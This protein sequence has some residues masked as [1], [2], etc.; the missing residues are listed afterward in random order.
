MAGTY[1]LRL[2]AAPGR[3]AFY[4]MV[5]FAFNVTHPDNLTYYETTTG[6]SLQWTLRDSYPA[7]PSTVRVYRNDTPGP[8]LE[9]TWTWSCEIDLPVEG[10]SPGWYEYTC[11]VTHWTGIPRNDTV[12]VHVLPAVLTLSSPDNASFVFGSAPEIQWAVDA[13]FVDVTFYNVSLGTTELLAGSWVPGSTI[14]FTPS[15]FGVGVHVLL[16]DV[17]DGL[18]NWTSD[19]IQVTVLNI[20]TITVPADLVFTAGTTGN[21]LAWT[22]T[23]AQ[24][25][26]TS[27]DILVDGGI[28]AT[29]TW[30]NAIAITYTLDSLPVGVHVVTI[31][32]RDGLGTTRQDEVTVTVEAAPPAFPMEV[33]YIGLAMGAVVA[34]SAIF[35]VR[36]RKRRTFYPV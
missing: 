25:G 17:T 32:A 1:Y 12:I 3:A 26:S 8:L 6:H 30:I 16:L 18:G 2:R 28:V 15:A 33:V 14:N 21:V 27:Y 19:E 29:G 23:A 24:I 20:F 10:L 4:T 31:I 11:A 5:T 35:R 34:I 36:H 22:P 7:I 9:Q 13:P